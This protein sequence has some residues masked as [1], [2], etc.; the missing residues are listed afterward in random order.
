MTGLESWHQALEG[1]DIMRSRYGVYLWLGLHRTNLTVTCMIYHAR[2]RTAALHAGLERAR[3]MNRLTVSLCVL[4]SSLLFLLPQPVG[5]SLVLVRAC[6][7][8]NVQTELWRADG[9]RLSF[10]LAFP[11]F[12]FSCT[13]CCCYAVCDVDSYDSSIV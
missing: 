10:I 5:L 6:C 2:L 7:L 9:C 13:C 4:C 8:G 3:L 1:W 12:I 11:H